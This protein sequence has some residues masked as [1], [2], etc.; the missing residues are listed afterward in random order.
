[1]LTLASIR[2]RVGGDLHGDANVS[3]TGVNSLGDACAT[4]VAPFD[5]AAY[6]DAAEASAAGAV[7]VTPKLAGR[8]EGNSLVHD[9][10]VAAMNVVIEMLG[11][12][13]CRP[14]PGVHSTAVIHPDTVL[15]PDVSVGPFAVIGAPVEMGAGCVIGPHAVLQAGVRMGAE[16]VIEAGAVLHE[17]TELGKGVVIGTGAV[18]AR[19]GFGFTPS[20][21]GPVHIHHVGRVIVGDHS[22]IGAYCSIDR[23]RFGV[24]RI[25]SMSGLDYGIHV[26][27]NARVGDRSFMAA[28][29]G[30]AGHAFVGDDC[31][32]GGQAGFAN[33]SGV[34]DRCRVGAK[35][36]LNK[37]FGDD[38]KLWGILAVDYAQSM[39]MEATLRRLAQRKNRRTPAKDEA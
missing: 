26:G 16:C 10:P 2:D 23:A 7:I 35:S 17:G 32:I 34:G 6:G 31:E 4:D 28:Q 19:P 37:D 13:P 27:H 5:D 29:S 3:I 11:Q 9:F 30:M 14:A 20:A 1:M 25:G 24:T 39:R 36:G 21:T 8:I 15:P 18:I 38:R 12:G 22:H 33:H